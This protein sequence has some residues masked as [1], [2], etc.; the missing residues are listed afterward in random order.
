AAVFT[1]LTQD[2]LDFHPTMED[3]FLA[4]RRLFMPAQ[5]SAPQVSVVNAGDPYGRRL[6]EDLPAVTSFAVAAEADYSAH[7]L[8]CGF[9]GCRMTLRTPAGERDLA[10]PMPGHF[11]VANALGALAAVHRLGFDLDGLLE[12]L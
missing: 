8:R 2:H 1:N 7:D 4:K 9:D 6:A 5:G 12:T 11:N 3:Y 10:L